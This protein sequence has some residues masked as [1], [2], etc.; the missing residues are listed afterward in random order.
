MIEWSRR[1]LRG[2]FARDVGGTLA[3]T[4]VTLVAG[5]LQAVVLARALGPA[6][7]GVIAIVLLV[8]GILA[9][10]LASGFA[11]SCVYFATRASAE[12]SMRN[13]TTYCAAAST[14]GVLV[15]VALALTG[16]LDA[17]APDLDG[18]LFLIAAALL[19]VAIAQSLLGGLLTGLGHLAQVNRVRA[20][21]AV[22]TLA[23]TVA[24]AVAGN[25]REPEVI[26]L[27]TLVVWLAATAVQLRLMGRHGAP[28]QLGFDRSLLGRQLAYAIRDHPGTVLQ[29]LNYRLDQIFVS[30]YLG[31][32]G[33]GLYTVA[34]TLGELLWLLPNSIATVIFPRA[35]RS[36]EG[37]GRRS[38]VIVA[39]ASL[40]SALIGALVLAAAGNA[41]ITTLFS[42]DFSDAYDALLWLLP[43]AVLLSPVKVLAADLAGRGYPI[44]NSLCAACGLVVTVVL[45]VALIPS[46]GVEGAAMASSAAYAVVTLL[47]LAAFVS[48]PGTQE[49]RGRLSSARLR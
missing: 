38:A 32:A 49:V 28:P 35:S 26:A 36:H 11:A 4:I 27:G 3:A 9:T 2:R 48:L 47:V 5:G 41:L 43:G 37:E 18:V 40:A 29:F 6:G 12:S 20:I 39:A 45:D 23:I 30:G 10:L 25:S 17:V 44:I 15:V 31:A 19:P 14:L 24:V 13:A 33:V 8:P 22:A 34:V 46:R 1:V 42:S 16:L 7:K 21:A